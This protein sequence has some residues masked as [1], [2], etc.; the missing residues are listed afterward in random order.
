MVKL[1]FFP[2]PFLLRREF[3]TT[4]LVCIDWKPFGNY[5]I[6]QWNTNTSGEKPSS[7]FTTQFQKTKKSSSKHR[8]CLHCA[9]NNAPLREKSVLPGC[10]NTSIIY[11]ELYKKSKNEPLLSWEITEH[12]GI[13]VCIEF[14]IVCIH[15]PYFKITIAPISLILQSQ[16]PSLK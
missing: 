6:C 14:K 16:L 13:C 9:K 15:G 2:V 8:L 1:Q 3:F 12:R 10:V 4:P 5:S 11:K 7:C